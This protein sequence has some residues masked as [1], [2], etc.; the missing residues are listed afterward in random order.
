MSSK[1]ERKESLIHGIG[2]FALVDIPR[3]TKICVGHHCPI[4]KTYYRTKEIGFFNYSEEP[5]AITPYRFVRYKNGL[6]TIT[7][8]KAIKNIKKGEEITLKYSWYDPTKPETEDNKHYRPLPDNVY[9]KGDRLYASKDIDIFNEF[10]TT[11]NFVK[12]LDRY[13]A[14]PLG[15][16]LTKDKDPNC[17]LITTQAK[18]VLIST[19][20]IK[21]DTL[22]TINNYE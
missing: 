18:K 2:T 1:I 15:G 11:H 7:E 4:H 17:K 16:F 10:G 12:Y 6:G 21:K 14:N 13:V 20:S 8:V 19:K 9:L 22:L 5:N 3:K